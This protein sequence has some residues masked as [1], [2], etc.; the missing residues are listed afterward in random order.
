MTPQRRAI[1]VEIMS[2]VGHIAP[3]EIAQRVQDRVPGVNT[4]TIYRTLELL[5]EAGFLSHS[6][7]ERGADYH[8]AEDHDHVHFVCLGC[9]ET[10]TAHVDDMEPLRATVVKRD[11]FLPDFTHYAIAG[12]CSNCRAS[13]KLGS[14][15]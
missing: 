7:H 13:R 5:E 10:H 14:K 2:S 11:G 9:G 6:H 4:S 3:Q 8:H 12:Y 1:V 15:P